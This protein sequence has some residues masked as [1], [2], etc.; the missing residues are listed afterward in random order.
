MGCAESLSAA[1]ARE[2]ISSE[3]AKQELLAMIVAVV[4]KAA[5]AS[6]HHGMKKKEFRTAKLSR[7]DHSWNATA[8]G[9]PVSGHE[10]TLKSAT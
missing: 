9:Q 3:D 1:A 2:E 4:Q 7:A 8:D 10:A 6:H 5:R